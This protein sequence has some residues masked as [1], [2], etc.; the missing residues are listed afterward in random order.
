LDSID[1]KKIVSIGGT[2]VI[3]MGFYNLSVIAKRLV[4]EGMPA[5]TPVAVIEWG[6]LPRQRSCLSE[7]SNIASDVRKK[8][9]KAPC[10][11]I[12]GEVA[13]LG[14]KLNWYEKLPLFGKSVVVTRSREKSGTLGTRLADLGAEVIE[15]PL[16]RIE[17]PASFLGL[18]RALKGVR[19]FD[20]LVFTSSAGVEAFFDRMNWHLLDARSLGGVRVASVGP[21][22]SAALKRS[23]LRPDLE[24]AR[25]E[26]AAIVE[27]FKRIYG[28]LQ[29]DRIAVFQA[30]GAPDFLK[31][32]LVSLGADVTRVDAYRTTAAGAPAPDVKKR[33]SSGRVDWVTFTSGSTAENFTKYFGRSAAARVSRRARFASIG[34]VTSRTMKRLGLRV[35]VQ[36]KTHDL[37]G[38]IGAITGKNP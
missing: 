34:P 16:I 17:P 30:A 38:L 26:S 35:A 20:W 13:A 14:R 27:D 23:G 25:Y 3:Y 21:E 9:L 36:A 12:V 6:T 22:T 8:N 28:S 5:R 7:L 24:P 18:D 31:K 33:I 1:W 2:L 4:A 37:N 15:L 32:S 11:I 19:S 29:G 10:I